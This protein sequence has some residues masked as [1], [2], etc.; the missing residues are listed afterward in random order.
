[1]FLTPYSPLWL[2][3]KRPGEVPRPLQE[4]RLAI[5]TGLGY[6]ATWVDSYDDAMEKIRAALARK[7]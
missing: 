6:S 3:F 2:E 1:V 4:N 7:V 5:L